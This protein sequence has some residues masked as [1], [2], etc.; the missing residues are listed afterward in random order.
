MTTPRRLGLIVF[1]LITACSSVGRSQP[2][3]LGASVPAASD[4]ASH[5]WA[6]IERRGGPFLLHLPPR[7]PGNGYEASPPGSVR[8][9]RPLAEWP[10][11]IAAI[12][13][14]VYLVYPPE[15]GAD[16]SESWRP[17]FSLRAVPSTIAGMWVDLP[18][19][20]MDSLPSLPARGRLVA[21][22]AQ[23]SALYVLERAAG[24][25]GMWAHDTS[26]PGAEWVAV[27]LPAALA[28]TEPSAIAMVSQRPGLVIAARETGGSRAWQLGEQDS[29]SRFDLRGWDRFWSAHWR[30]GF[31]REILAATPTGTGD[32]PSDALELWR[33][34]SGGPASLGILAAARPGALTSMPSPGRLV[35]IRP[36]NAVPEGQPPE[37]V[38]ILERSLITGR[39]LHDGA[40]GG[41]VAVPV[42]ELRAITVLL[43]LMMA[44]VLI[45]IIRPNPERSW[46]IPDGWVLADP[47]RRLIASLIDLVLVAAVLAPAFGV[48]ARQIL[49]L[50]VLIHPGGAWLSLP[51]LLLTGW[52]SMS[53]WESLLGLTPGKFV[54]ACRVRRATP[55]ADLKVTIFWSLVRNA[56]KW[57]T[58]PVAAIALF[59][60]EGRHRGDS[61]ARA[62]VVSRA[63]AS[64]SDS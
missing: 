52:I 39:T 50:E 48:S 59:D 24:H 36:G 4:A 64:P 28:G 32:D 47:G 46:S 58:P 53:V 62:V 9:V 60:A 51:A 2:V 25:L 8:P 21:L 33:L 20:L 38:R 22:A 57:L 5:G 44:A 30:Q 40:G 1:L 3:P 23:G 17:V 56:M 14:R 34:G 41:S 7:E 11:A 31:G 42:T 26:A 16:Q 45:V 19:G 15:P 61:A 27:P 10:D 18:S 63:P 29:W 54:T 35:L 6:V 43:V 13:D 37:P 49:T 12:G 55:G